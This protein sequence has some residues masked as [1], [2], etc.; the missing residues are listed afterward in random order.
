M[1]LDIVNK[2]AKLSNHQNNNNNNKICHTYLI[3]VN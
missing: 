3:E 1:L 2:D